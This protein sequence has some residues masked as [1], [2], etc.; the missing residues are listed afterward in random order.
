LSFKLFDLHKRRS[1]AQ[2]AFMA[3]CP[4]S[5]FWHESRKK[6]VDPMTVNTE[7]TRCKATKRFFLTFKSENH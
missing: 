2:C 7:E 1:V 6:A 3:E 5:G 4:H